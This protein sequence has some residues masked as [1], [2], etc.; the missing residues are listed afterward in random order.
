[1]DYIK[2][3]EVK[4][5]DYGWIDTSKCPCGDM[6][7]HYLFIAAPDIDW[8]Y[9]EDVGS[10]QGVVFAIGM[11]KDQWFI[12]KDY[13]GSCS[14]CGAWGEGGE[15][16]KLEDV[17]SHGELFDIKEQAKQFVEKTYMSENSWDEQPTEKF[18]EILKG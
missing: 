13:Y 8:I 6:Y 12:M 4:V 3:I 18:M 11:Y 7:A 16:E 9:V 1:M 10:Y 2:H 17:L 15:P 5:G 14:G